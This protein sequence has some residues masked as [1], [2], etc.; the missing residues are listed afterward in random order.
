LARIIRLTSR[1]RRLH[2]TAVGAHAQIEQEWAQTVGA[3]RYVDLRGMLLKL[4]LQRYEHAD[5]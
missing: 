1:R 5:S 4:V 2:Q 3:Q